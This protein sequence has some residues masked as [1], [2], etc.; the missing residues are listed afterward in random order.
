METFDLKPDAPNE[1]RGEFR[2]IPTNVPGVEN[3]EHLTR[4]S[5]LADKYALVRSLHHDRR[6]SRKGSRRLINRG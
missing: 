4:L 3:S 5:Q 1:Y 2:P 6:R